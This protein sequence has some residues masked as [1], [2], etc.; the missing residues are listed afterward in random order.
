LSNPAYNLPV[1]E[2]LP[3]KLLRAY[4]RMKIKADQRNQKRK[5][6]KGTWNP[7]LRDAVLLKCQ[8]NSDAI[9]GVLGKFQRPYDGPYY[10]SK[11]VNPS[12]YELRDEN[13]KPGGL[14]HIQYLKP[15]LKRKNKGATLGQ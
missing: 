14:F 2:N 4:A 7:K 13:G 5:K 15:Y 12:L 8:H 10:I 1:Q 3:Q 6:G 9:H 11:S